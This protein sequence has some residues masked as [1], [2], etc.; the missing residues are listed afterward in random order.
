MSATKNIVTVSLV[1]FIIAVIAVL[2][3]AVF[4]QQG[5][6]NAAPQPQ[7][8]SQ[9]ASLTA[10]VSE[11]AGGIPIAEIAKHGSES[12]C[13]TIV[14]AKV[15]NVTDFL[16][17]HPAGPDKITPFCGKDGSEAFSTRSGKGPHPDKSSITLNDYFIGNLA[18]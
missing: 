13:W 1:I 8:N 3:G 4:M 11:P 15:Y 7:Q 17:K 5:K 18:Q 14:G 12:D 2:A 16:T 9:Q 6:N 10:T